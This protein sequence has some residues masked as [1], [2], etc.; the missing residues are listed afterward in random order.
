MTTQQGPDRSFE[1]TQAPVRN[2]THAP[3]HVYT[4]QEVLDYERDHIFMKDWLCVGREEEIE[5]PGDYITMRILGEPVILVRSEA[6]EVNA[7]SNICLHRGMELVEGSGNKRAFS[8]PFHAWS[9]DLNGRLLGAPHMKDT[10]D[11]DV[12]K[13]RLAPIKVA[14]WK[15]WIFI[16]FDDNAGPLASHVADLEKD[17]GYLRQEDCRLGIKTVNEINCNWKLVCENLIDYYHIPVVHKK[18]NGRTFTTESFKFEPRPNGGYVAMF[19]SGPSTPSGKPVFGKIPWIADRP[20]DFSTGGRLW[21]NLNFFARIDTVHPI[22]VWPITPHK[23]L[24]I[25]YTLLPKQYLDEP[26]FKERVQAYQDYQN[27]LLV[28]DA[29]MLDSVQRGLQSPRFRPGRMAY[30]ERGVHHV[31]NSYLERLEG[32]NQEPDSGKAKASVS[33]I[34]VKVEARS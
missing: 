16:N 22:I 3:A 8:C 15:R 11:F 33:N 5:K 4:S 23:S 30:I 28:E 27:D 31:L 26:N 1:A 13:H 10:E 21:P 25:V 7:F 34:K 19:N 12:S 14:L 29:A 9:Y 17:F 6:G 20:D 2:A 24:M 32:M 18:T